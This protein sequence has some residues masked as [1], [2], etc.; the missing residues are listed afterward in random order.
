MRKKQTVI[1]Y[2]Q[3]FADELRQLSIENG[4]NIHELAEYLI[5]LGIGEKKE[6]F[7]Q[8]YRV[9]HTL[10]DFKGNNSEKLLYFTIPE[11]LYNT[12]DYCKFRY[13]VSINIVATTLLKAGYCRHIL[14]DIF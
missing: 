14:K 12:F 7:I 8:I 3:E 9:Y 1:R 10:F 6:Q 2:S 5:R 13:G 4:V 11:D